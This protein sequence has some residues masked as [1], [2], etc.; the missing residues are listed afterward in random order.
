MFGD[1]SG[2]GRV[3]Y[4]LLL[5][6]DG[7]DGGVDEEDPGVPEVINFV[8]ADLGGHLKYS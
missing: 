7:E 2:L 6:S 4:K 3:L 8:R 5:E 1:T